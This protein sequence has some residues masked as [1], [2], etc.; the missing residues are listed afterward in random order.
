[1]ENNVRKKIVQEYYSK[2]ARDYDW[3]K[4]RTWKSE[5]GLGAELINSVIDGLAH[6]EG[7]HILEVGIGSGRIGFPLMKK[8][9]PY[10]VGLDLSREMLEHAKA[11]VSSCNQ[12][13]DIALGDAEH[14]PF[15]EEV[16]DA[17]VCIS[18]MHYF[19]DS[20][21][22]LTEFLRV[23][24]EKGVFVF[25][26]LTLHETDNRR[27]LDTLEKTL[28]RAHAKYFKPSEM[29]RLLETCGFHVSRV[30]VTPYRKSYLSL[31]EDKGRYFDVKPEALDKCIQGATAHERKLYSMSDTELTLFYTLITALK[32]SKL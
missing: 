12:K 25:G 32:E 23:L 2:R 30:K 15:T 28:S 3:Q 31:M 11:K 17:I 7:K 8:V 24:K 4:I 22:G 5:Q 26:D 9:K 10:L 16:F 13:F 1:M 19:A 29:K 21:P 20:G 27:F 18:T 14:L 6:F